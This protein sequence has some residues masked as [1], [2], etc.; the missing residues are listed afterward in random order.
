MANI[1]KIEGKD[2]KSTYQITVS[3]GRDINGK[4]IRYYKTYKPSDKMTQRQIEKELNRISIEF[5]REIELGIAL[6]NRQTFAKYAEYVMAL[7]ERTG[8]KHLTLNRYKSLLAAIMPSIGH[9]KIADLRPQHLNNLYELLS[10]DGQNKITGGKL[11]NKTIVEHHR[12]ISTILSQA[13]KEMLVSYN[14]A[15]KATPPKVEKKEPNY[16]Q[17][18]DVAKICDCLKNEPIKF[19]TATYLLLVTGCR[20]GEIMGLKWTKV[21]FEK[22]QIKIDSNLLY[23]SE[24]GIFLDT[25][26]TATSNRIVKLPYETMQL[27]KEYKVWYLEQRL[28]AGSDWAK[29]D[30]L[31]TQE[32]GTP[33]HPDTLTGWLDKFAK[34]HGLAH[35][36]PHAFR[37]TMASILYY[38]G[39]DSITISKRLGHAKVSTTTDIYSHIMKQADEEAAN[40]ISELIFK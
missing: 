19:K 27:L 26:K 3:N 10:K 30:F 7:K 34:R 32:D 2:G 9:I 29:S 15:R 17:I 20:R 21:D 23:T 1:R 12:L 40:C 22:N 28:F 5:E 18:D 14:V 13:E 16:F 39:V 24:K 35:I 31:F 36:N 37:H 4:Q 6:D 8:V 33:M 25:T 38:K 11:S